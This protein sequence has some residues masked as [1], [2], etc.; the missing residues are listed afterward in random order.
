MAMELSRGLNR[1]PCRLDGRANGANSG[2]PAGRA[3]WAQA[4]RDWRAWRC[5]P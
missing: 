2:K 5:L 1:D 4:D 3:W